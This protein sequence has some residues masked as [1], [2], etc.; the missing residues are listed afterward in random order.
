MSF[1]HRLSYRP[2]EGKAGCSLLPGT[3]CPANQALFFTNLRFSRSTGYPRHCQVWRT[4]SRTVYTRYTFWQVARL[5]DIH[6]KSRKGK[7]E[8]SLQ[9]TDLIRWD[10]DV[11]PARPRGQDNQMVAVTLSIRTLAIY[12]IGK[13]TFTCRTLIIYTFPQ[14][15]SIA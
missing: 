15:D 12:F 13:I 11:S 14:G 4:N 6:V 7:I 2:R 9:L 10:R 3:D 1:A 5:G 8:I